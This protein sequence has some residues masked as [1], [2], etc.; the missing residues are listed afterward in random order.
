M[1]Q[2]KVRLATV[3]SGIGSI[4]F[5]FKRLG[6]PTEIVFAC[7][8]GER[9]VEYDKE[10]EFA[11]V[12]KLK[13]IKAKKEYVDQLYLGLT[14]SHN[15]VEESYLANYK[16]SPDRYF[17]DVCLLDGNDFSG[18][19]DLFVGGSPCQSFSAVGFQK[20]LEDARGT[21]F[22]EFARLVNE[23]KPNVFIYENVRNM[24]NH[25][26]GNTW[27]I[28]QGVFDSLG[29]DLDVE[30]LNAV[31]FGI[32]QKRNRLFV[33]GVKKELGIKPVLP[34]KKEGA[35]Q[36]TMQDFLI[37]NCAFGNFTHNAL[38][39]IQIKKSSGPVDD[40]YFLSDAVKRYV[41]KDG[42]K[43]WHQRGGTDLPIAR[44]LLKTM[45]NC[46]RSG[47]DNYVTQDGQLRMLTER[48]CHRLMG[49]TDDYKI[50]V[51]IAQAYKQAGNSIVVD[52]MMTIIQSLIKEGLLPVGDS[53]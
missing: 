48:E 39:E 51:S 8:N 5:A 36:Y 42:T 13:T 38:G 9:E 7:D 49:Y 1:K 10:K 46:H 16:I 20:G 53:K 18:K 26:H 2:N 21:L 35:S 47:V 11:E 25:D 23:I 31:D 19:V 44:T 41:L 33:L 52:V 27:E 17:Q 6:I 24:L 12:K 28:I 43:N 14:R 50:P 40:R 15:F 30:I 29:Y 34:L 3:F 37:N 45:G 22:Y 32:P 4:E